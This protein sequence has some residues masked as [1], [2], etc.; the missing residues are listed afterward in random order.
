MKNTN[1]NA[2]NTEVDLTHVEVKLNEMLVVK[3]GLFF[4][5]RRLK[6]GI[7]RELNR[8]FQL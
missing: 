1:K 6:N 3:E 8:F 4:N 5:T 7:S 2:N